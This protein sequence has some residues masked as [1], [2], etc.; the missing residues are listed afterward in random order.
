MVARDE[1]IVVVADVFFS[2]EPPVTSSVELSITRVI[3]PL[4]PNGMPVAVGVE[5]RSVVCG[6]H[7]SRTTT[8][9][10]IVRIYSVDAWRR[11]FVSRSHRLRLGPDPHAGAGSRARVPFT[12]LR[13]RNEKSATH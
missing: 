5:L 10:A 9:I 8:R 7:E 2:G 1:R 13:I 12:P 6:A 3:V 4:K 11:V